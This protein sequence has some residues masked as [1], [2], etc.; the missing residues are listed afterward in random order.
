MNDFAAKWGAAIKRGQ[1]LLEKK[2]GNHTM[3]GIGMSSGASKGIGNTAAITLMPGVVVDAKNAPIVTPITKSYSEG[4]NTAGYWAAAHGARSGNIQK[5][6]QSFK[7]GWLTK[8]LIN[9]IYDTRIES[10]DP[11]D[12]EGIEYAI[13]DSKG[14]MNRY[15]ARDVV[16]PGG[17]VVAKRNEVVT[18]DLI[19][20]LN[21]SKV[22]SVYVQSPLTD[23]TPGDGFSSYSYGVDHGG[24]KKNIGDNIGVMAAHT[25]T[26][27]SLNMAMKAFHTGGALNVNKKAGDVTATVFDALFDTLHFSKKE[28]DKGV[29]A[30]MNGVITD[31]E[32]SSIGG[33]NVILSNGDKQ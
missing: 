22:S 2:N 13:S 32:K 16:T 5:S 23:P 12:A 10:E 21:Q 1:D 8:D 28:S 18:S 7:P 27:P 14:I 17:K 6:V 33:W 25:I 15:L 20:R 30:S 26:E 31:I 24:K 3:L 11:Q 9:S 19:N 29:M 4:L